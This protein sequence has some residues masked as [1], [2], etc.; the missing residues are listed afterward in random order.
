MSEPRSRYSLDSS[1]VSWVTSFV[2]KDLD[3][4]EEEEEEEMDEEEHEN[5]SIL[6]RFVARLLGH[7]V[8]PKGSR[9][10][11]VRERRRK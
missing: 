8:H 9:E 10:E 2:R 7:F 3:E 11:G 6:L 1:H 5:E 4:E